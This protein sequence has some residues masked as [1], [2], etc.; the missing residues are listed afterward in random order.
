VVI[1]GA[2]VYALP[3]VV[4]RVAVAR[5]HAGTG[6]PVSIGTVQ[7]NLLTGR[8]TIRH[9]QVAG[10]EKPERFVDIDRLDT[11][12]HLPSLLRGRIWIRDLRISDSTV[13][14]VRMPGGDFNVSDLIQ[15]SGRVTRPID[16]T[17]DHFVV[18]GGTVTLEDRALR[19]PRTWESRQIEIDAR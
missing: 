6:R 4:R 11:L 16:V 9:V 19:E 18:T 5:I 13:R 7:L 14:V 15:A 17:V 8:L 10:R 12:V 1:A 2:T 3:E